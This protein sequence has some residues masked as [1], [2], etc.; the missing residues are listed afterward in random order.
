MNWKQLPTTFQYSER[1]PATTAMAFSLH[2]HWLCRVLRGV[3]RMLSR[4]QMY[5]TWLGCSR[6]A[7]LSF[8]LSLVAFWQKRS[9]DKPEPAPHRG[10]Q[11]NRRSTAGLEQHSTA[12]YVCLRGREASKSLLQQRFIPRQAS[13][14]CQRDLVKVQ[15]TWTQSG[16]TDPHEVTAFFSFF[17]VSQ[18]H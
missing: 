14:Q 7:V 4:P 16:Q 18:L 17:F 5:A 15:M 3:P 6:S 10:T 8:V 13:R 9:R 2:N 12:G 11:Q 1:R